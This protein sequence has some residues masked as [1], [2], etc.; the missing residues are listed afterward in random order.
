MTALDEQLRRFHAAITGA[1]PLDSAAELVDAPRDVAAV[2]RLHV[3]A[4]AYTAR[5]AGVLALEYPKLATRVA[6]PALVAPYLRAHPPSR[7]SL[8]AVGAH[9]AAFLAARGEPAHLVELAAL[10]RARTEAFDGGRDVVP[11][12]RAD[13]AAA[14]AAAFP[15][16]R[17]ALVPSARVVPLTSNADDL[18]DAIERGA[19]PPPP[20]PATRAVLVWRRDVTVVHR[21]L[22]ADE[23]TLAPDLAAGTTFE[24]I[25]DRLAAD[26]AP[27]ERALALLLRWVDAGVLTCSPPS[28]T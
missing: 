24:A 8:A 7:P 10:E 19:A 26:P 20:A 25:C 9:L 17:L 14:G 16:L 6:L 21:T 4:H 11:L 2:E 15:A 12:A 5:I 22:D 23:A 3:Y 27:A 1:A 13:L 18:W 28:R